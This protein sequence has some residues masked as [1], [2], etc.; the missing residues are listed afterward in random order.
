MN[1]VFIDSDVILDLLAKRE[2]Y[3]IHSAKLFTL[4]DQNF[5]QG[6]TSA[7]SYVNIHY[8]LSRASTSKI[9]IQS[10][11]RLKSMISI[12][13]I[14]ESIIENALSSKFKDFED[15]VQYYCALEND[16]DC[17]ITRNKKDYT[18]SKI[19]VCTAEEYLSILKTRN[20]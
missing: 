5:V 9:A 17:I 18:Q 4:I 16:L 1:R 2:P 12:L 11:L 15:A 20:D 6:Y 13:T 19:T 3:Y 10:L 8:I 7:N 14:D